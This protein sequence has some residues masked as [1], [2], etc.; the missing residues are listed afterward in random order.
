M[1]QEKHPNILCTYWLKYPIHLEA[2]RTV[3]WDVVVAVGTSHPA[4]Y[5]FR[6]I[7]G[8]RGQITEIE[9]TTVSRGFQE[10]ASQ[11]R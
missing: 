9:R 6:G 1:D 2:L 8:Q 10:A 3:L 4:I 11:W 5:P 7:S